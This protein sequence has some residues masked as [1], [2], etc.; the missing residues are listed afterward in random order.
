MCVCVRA[1]VC[2][3]VVGVVGGCLCWG[4]Y[5]CGCGGW[6][7]VCGCGGW[8]FVCL[9]VCIPVGG[10]VGGVFMCWVWVSV[11]VCVH[12]PVCTS[13]TAERQELAVFRSYHPGDPSPKLYIKNLARQVTEEVGHTLTA[14]SI[15]F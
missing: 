7:F 8:V 6:V 10:C 2:V 12:A 1:Y 14:M 3:C 9:C 13:T 4:I 11:F 5:V 15:T